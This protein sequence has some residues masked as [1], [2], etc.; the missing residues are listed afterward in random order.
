VFRCAHRLERRLAA[1]AA[2]LLEASTADIVIA[3][4]HFQVRGV[5]TRTVDLAAVVAE[6]RRTGVATSDEEW[7]VPGSQ[8]FPYGVHAA[9]VDVDAETGL[10]EIVRYVAVDDCGVVVHPEMVE[11]QTIGSVAQGIGQA[12]FEQVTYGDDGQ[13]LSGTLI[14]YTI[15][16]ASD[17]PADVRTD[18]L[19]SPA[20]SNSLG[21]KGAGEGGCIGAPPAVVNAVLDAL[22]PLGVTHLDMPLYP[23]RVWQA[24]RDA[25][26]GGPDT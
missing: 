3:D 23:H 12:L 18:R 22:A 16:G 25:G 26:Y 5:P 15:P 1:V 21:A 14:D 9:V 2:N 19:V 11:G 8:T 13:L 24:I 7:Y 17:L 20:P 4:A 10:I 6:G